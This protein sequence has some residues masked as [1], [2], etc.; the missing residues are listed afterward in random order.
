RLVEGADQVLALRRVDAGLAADAA[1]DL[2]E[3]AGGDLDEADAAAQDR[4][5]EAR[6]VADHAATEGDE[7]IAPLELQSQQ[8][9]AEAAELGE[10]LGRLAGW[11][12]DGTRVAT[13]GCE[14]RLERGQVMGRDILVGD[15]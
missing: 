5:R 11:H 13:D 7:T 6:E 8:R 4:G 15:D 12:H 10:A 2:G 3:Q 14:R 1:V 9:L